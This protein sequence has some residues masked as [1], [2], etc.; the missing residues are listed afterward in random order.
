MPVAAQWVKRRR[1]RLFHSS[2]GGLTPVADAHPTRTD[3]PDG[4][5][6]NRQRKA[7]GRH[8]QRIDLGGFLAKGEQGVA[9][10]LLPEIT[11]FPAAQVALARPRPLPIEQVQRLAEIV[12]RQGQR[13]DIHVRGIGALPGGEFFSF[14]VLAQFGFF[15]SRRDGFLFVGFGFLALD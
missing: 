13:S 1:G 5:S 7:V 12:S 14:G 8:C 6:A 3:R 15:G 9:A 10:G 11:P 2:P 4:H